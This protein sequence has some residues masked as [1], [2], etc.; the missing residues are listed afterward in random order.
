MNKE[1]DLDHIFAY[2][3]PDSE[4]TAR[5]ELIRNAAKMFANVILNNSPHSRRRYECKCCNCSRWKDFQR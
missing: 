5:Y 2:H 4:K 3:T 1:F